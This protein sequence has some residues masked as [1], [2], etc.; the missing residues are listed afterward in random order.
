MLPQIRRII[1]FISVVFL[2]CIPA[3]SQLSTPRVA[4]ESFYKFDRSRSQVFNR[5]NVDV[6]RKWLEHSLYSLLVT[7]LDREGEFLK[8]NPGEKPHYGDGLP[9]RPSEESCESGGK[10]FRR[11]V[12]V[13]QAVRIG[14]TATVPVTFAYPAA[15]RIEDIVY[16]V[17]LIGVKT[18]WLMVDIEYPDG[19]T[20]TADLKR[21][22]Y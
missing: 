22:A 4:V 12:K 14:E 13:G 3:H 15:C 16:K 17:K 10:P 19:E 2:L 7:E 11:I 6:R 18:L 20:L 9:F 5:R 1:V 21:V 8:A